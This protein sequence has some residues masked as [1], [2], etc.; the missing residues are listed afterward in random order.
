MRHRA[1]SLALTAALTATASALVAVPAQAASN[2]LTV[3]TIGR[4]GARITMPLVLTNAKTGQVV[5]GRKSG[6]SFSLAKGSWEVVV[7]IETPDNS[8]YRMSDTLAAVKVSVSGRTAVTLDARR[9]KRVSA[10]VDATSGAAAGSYNAFETAVACPANNWG[11]L[12]G[13]YNVP[14]E[15]YEI[16]NARATEFQFGWMQTWTGAD[17][18]AVN[19]TTKG[20]PANPTAYFRRSSMA[21]V[22]LAMRSGET[23]QP[24]NGVMANPSTGGQGCTDLLYGSSDLTGS[25]T[26]ATA[27]LSSGQWQ[28]RGYNTSGAWTLDTNDNRGPVKLTGGH[29]YWLN[30]GRAVWGPTAGLPV[31]DR[32]SIRFTPYATIADVNSGTGATA[33]TRNTVTLSKAGHVLKRQT[34]TTSYGSAP[35]FSAGIASA[36][37]YSLSVTSTRKLRAQLS[38]TVTLAWH[39]HAD[40]R[41]SEVAPGYLAKLTPAGLSAANKVPERSTTP[42]S[43]TLAR[44]DAPWTT[45]LRYAHETVK[46]LKVWAS[47][48]GGRTWHAVTVTRSGSHWLAKVPEPAQPGSVTLRTVAV[49]TAGNSSTQTVYNAFLVS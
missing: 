46:S 36:G 29:S 27:W 12:V 33:D 25:G 11:G 6:R 20:L 37:W 48:D 2:T 40:P 9:G 16:P 35:T 31:V 17:Y 21:R 38:T 42:V 44:T 7:D 4:N 28:V 19:R 14:G 22:N 32:R 30:F 24:V 1:L 43:I 49:D 41:V 3:T 45:G 39:F 34:L 26:D 13:V 15:I 47:H 5:T 18:Y 10:S 8:P 23:S